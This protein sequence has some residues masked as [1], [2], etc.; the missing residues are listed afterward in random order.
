LPG[1]ISSFPA[2]QETTVDDRPMN[3]SAAPFWVDLHQKT[4]GMGQKQASMTDFS[5]SAVSSTADILDAIF[6]H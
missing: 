3:G 4:S 2:T 5:R 1:D 6:A